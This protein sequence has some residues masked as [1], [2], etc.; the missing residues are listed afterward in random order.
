MR[1]YLDEHV[2]VAV[3]PAL[4]AHGVDCLSTQ[5]AGNVGLSDEDQLAFATRSGRVLVTFNRKDF[6]AL[7]RRWHEQ[8]RS[9][10]GLI[11]SRELPVS[12]LLRRFRQFL[13]QHQSGDFTDQVF[14]LAS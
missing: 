5:E 10:A 13:Q 9:H 14:W 7:A 8:G 6:L 12:E 2:P 4:V 11:L 3:A 1:L